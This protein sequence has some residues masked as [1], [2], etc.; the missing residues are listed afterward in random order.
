MIKFPKKYILKAKKKKNKKKKEKKK[1]KRKRKNASNY[2]F[3]TLV[4]QTI[5]S[6]RFVGVKMRLQLTIIAYN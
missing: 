2:Y 5:I 1:K 6:L 4:S 3:K